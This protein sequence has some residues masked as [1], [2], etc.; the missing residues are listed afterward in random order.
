MPPINTWPLLERPRERLL[1]GGPKGLSDA[2]LLAI[3]LRNGVKGKDAVSLARELLAKF[4]GLRGLLSSGPRALKD[5]KG[6]GQV[7]LQRT[8]LVLPTSQYLRN[9]LKCKDHHCSRFQI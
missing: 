5:E 8:S 2:E 1:A 3:L 6:L 7:G 4:G 9:R